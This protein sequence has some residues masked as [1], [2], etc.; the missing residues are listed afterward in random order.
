MFVH[1]VNVKVWRH[2][3]EI[4]MQCH[5]TKPENIAREVVIP[6]RVCVGEHDGGRD[7]HRI[8]VLAHVV[9]RDVIVV[10]RAQLMAWLICVPCFTAVSYTHLTLPTNREV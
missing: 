6:A 7:T 9:L 4:G 8:P 3:R 2:T 1:R 5:G 10:Q